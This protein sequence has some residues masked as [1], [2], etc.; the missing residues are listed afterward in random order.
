MNSKKDYKKVQDSRIVSVTELILELLKRVRLIIIMALIFAVVL[1]GYKYVKDKKAANI[2]LLSVSVEEA[3]KNLTDEEVEQVNLAEYTQKSLE[4]KQEYAEKSVL[5]QLNPYNVTTASIQFIIETDDKSQLTDLKYAYYTYVNDGQLL[6]DL[7]NRGVTEDTHYLDEIISYEDASL[8]GSNLNS[9]VLTTNQG[10]VFDVTVKYTDQESCEKL[11]GNIMTCVSEYA[12]TL[13]E[14]VYAHNIRLLNCSYSNMVD[15]T[16]AQQQNDCMTAINTLKD[17]L[18][19]QTESFN[20]NQKIVFTKE[21]Q[22]KASATDKNNVV[23]A[24][25]ISKKYIC[26]GGVIGIVLA[27]IYIVIAYLL[28]GT[29]NSSND[30]KYLYNRRV[31]AEL[32]VSRKNYLYRKA[33]QKLLKDSASNEMDASVEL[34][35]SNVKC[36]CEK[37]NIHEVICAYSCDDR[38]VQT[39][40]ERVEQQL[41]AVGIKICKLGDGLENAQAV[42][43]MNWL[44]YIILVEKLSYA[45][46]ETITRELEICMEQGME[47]MGLVTLN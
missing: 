11:A 17:Q 39:W 29:I 15:A 34:L 2:P 14:S 33:R 16:V 1:G 12:T 21:N 9:N 40:M 23:P 24:V 47:L 32:P 4:K 45:R 30:V 37:N 38:F 10:S 25:S 5:M 31:L 22:E 26:L 46:Y 36:E 35:V 8:N 7:K 20:E 43:A 6:Q 41:S 18:K 42:E 44:K 19:Q 27:I 13:S 28:R 3:E